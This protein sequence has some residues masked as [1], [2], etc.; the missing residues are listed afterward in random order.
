MPT[1]RRERRVLCLTPRPGRAG[2]SPSLPSPLSAPSWPCLDSETPTNH[3][4]MCHPS[5]PGVLALFHLEKPSFSCPGWWHKGLTSP[6]GRPCG[7][8]S[9]KAKEALQAETQAALSLAALPSSPNTSHMPETLEGRP[10][11]WPIRLAPGLPEG[12]LLEAANTLTQHPSSLCRLFGGISHT[13]SSFSLSL[14]ESSISAE[15]HVSL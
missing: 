3:S 14:P 7:I 8:M 15:K 12:T 2:G 1:R 10:T 5:S 6:P 11:W 9:Q 4:S 13:F